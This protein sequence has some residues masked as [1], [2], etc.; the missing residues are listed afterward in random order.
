MLFPKLATPICVV[1][2]TMIRP[3][4]WTTRTIEMTMT[5]KAYL[6][7]TYCSVTCAYTSV[8]QLFYCKR[9]FHVQ[10][11]RANLDLFRDPRTLLNPDTSWGVRSHSVP[12]LCLSA[13]RNRRSD[14]TIPRHLTELS[15][16]SVT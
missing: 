6:N 5:S 12:D 3:A 1:D 8:R 15:V 11:V 2:L 9:R 16:L 13:R 10:F 4:S 14:R 7:A